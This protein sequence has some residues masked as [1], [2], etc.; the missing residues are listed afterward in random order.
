MYCQRRINMK[1]FALFFGLLFGNN[2]VPE[3]GAAVYL[4]S[5][6]VVINDKVSERIISIKIGRAHV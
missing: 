2:Y 1:T 3:D 5:E 4:R 6:T